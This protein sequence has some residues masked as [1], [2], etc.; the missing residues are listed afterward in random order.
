MKKREN[1]ATQTNE[2]KQK[3]SDCIRAKT[4]NY[5]LLPIANFT[6]REKMSE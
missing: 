1:K 6:K 2:T 4:R 5:R 3:R